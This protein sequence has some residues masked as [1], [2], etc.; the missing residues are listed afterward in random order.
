MVEQLVNDNTERFENSHALISRMSGIF[1]SFSFLQLIFY[2]RGTT[3]KI[4]PAK[5]L[6][7][8]PFSSCGF[9]LQ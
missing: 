4:L 5:K 7:T 9:I 1:S 8:S 3:V 2:K 6:R